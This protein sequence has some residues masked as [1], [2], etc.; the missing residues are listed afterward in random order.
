MNFSKGFLLMYIFTLP[1]I[2]KYADLADFPYMIIFSL[3]TF[4]CKIICKNT[5]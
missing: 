4:Y 5:K 1:F 3:G 2:I